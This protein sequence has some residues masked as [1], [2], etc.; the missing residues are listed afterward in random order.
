[1][2]A[3]TTVKRAS[4]H[5]ANEIERLG[6]H[7]G[8]TVFVEKGGEIIPKVTGIDFEARNSDTN[9]VKFI[10]SC[11]ECQTTLVR[12][13]G[14]AV[15]YCPNE[16][17]CPPQIQGRI[18]HF[19]QRKA[20]NIESMGPET[21]KGLLDHGLIKNS[22]D[23]YNLTFQQLNGLEFSVTDKDGSQKVRSLREKSA[24]N[25]I[26]AIQKS[27]E[28]PFDRVLFGMGIRFVGATVAEKLASHFR[29][30][31]RIMKASFEELIAAEDIGEKIAE[32]IIAYFKDDLN[33][34]YIQGLKEAGLKLELLEEEGA[35]KSDELDGL[36][37][38][39]SG[40][41]VKYGRDEIK[42]VIK[43]HGGKVVSSISKKL[44]FLLAGDKAGPSKLVKAEDLGVKIVD[45]DNFIQMITG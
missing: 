14:E 4:L 42:S 2:L 39:V 19:I 44:D 21:L 9:P 29:S 25:I 33:L 27:K 32:S 24:Q 23:L 36:T 17:G 6:L 41:F 18:E 11:P 7:I 3:G 15:H 34:L 12:K 16:N 40:V 22:S 5:N 30:I 28:A 31:D 37:F 38:V 8:D 35:M 43:A 20:M 1:L 13:E 45:E 26:S 10:S